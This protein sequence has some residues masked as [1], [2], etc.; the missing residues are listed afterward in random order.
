MRK[1]TPIGFKNKKVSDAER[2]LSATA[3]TLLICNA[4]KRKKQ[5]F[6]ALIGGYFLFRGV[7]GYCPL[8]EA[9]SPKEK[10]SSVDIA[11]SLTVNKPLDETYQF[12]RNLSGLPLFMKHLKTVTE[13]DKK[14]SIW[15][16][17]LPWKIGMLRWEAEIT[18]EQVNKLIEWQSLE[19][20][21]I[22]NRGSVHFKDAGKFGTEIQVRIYY[23]APAGKPGEL[24]AQLV[25]PAF[26]EMITEDI[27]N[28]RRYIETGEIP[29]TNGQPSNH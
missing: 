2:I 14:K 5:P 13:V 1:T 26:K 22:N 9:L 12:W 7:A 18:A 11:I 28:F 23:A 3:G 21:V 16:A 10:S 25:K 15:I 8:S 24:A 17:R 27:K 19:N 4:F 20:S 6:K 29:T